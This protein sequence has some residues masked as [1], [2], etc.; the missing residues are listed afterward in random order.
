MSE[1]NGSAF[2]NPC[3][4]KKGTNP[5]VAHRLRASAQPTRNDRCPA[6][7]AETGHP[8]ATS[9][10][11]VNALP[12]VADE[13]H[14]ATLIGELLQLRFLG[15]VSEV[16]R[17]AITR[18]VRKLRILSPEF[19]FGTLIDGSLALA[20]SVEYLTHHLDAPPSAATTTVVA[21]CRLEIIETAPAGRLRGRSLHRFGSFSCCPDG[22][23]P[24]KAA[25]LRHTQLA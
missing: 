11:P 3:C 9:G 20:F 21:R 5:R 1:P 12:T 16:E 18:R 2:G 6:K 8:P 13:R 15:R 17:N 10:Q 24:S 14:P 7:H 25:V 4:G 19:Q 23:L 22:S